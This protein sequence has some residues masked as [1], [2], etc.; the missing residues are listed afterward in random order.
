M[1]KKR[2]KIDLE[3]GTADAATR[4]QVAASILAVLAALDEVA[5]IERVHVRKLDIDGG[6]YTDPGL[7]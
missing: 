2:V 3:L 4:R 5:E 6:D 1:R 7:A